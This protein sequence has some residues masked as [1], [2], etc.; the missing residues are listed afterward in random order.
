VNIELFHSL[1]MV[2][3]CLF[4]C[5]SV[6]Q[7]VCDTAVR[8]ADLSQDKLKVAGYYDEVGQFDVTEQVS[9]EDRQSASH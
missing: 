5:F 7:I 4:V 6:I 3:V 2:C 8:Y 1:N 9:T